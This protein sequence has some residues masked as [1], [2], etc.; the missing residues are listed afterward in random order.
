MNPRHLPLNYLY[1]GGALFFLLFLTAG[2]VFTKENLG[3]SQFFFFLYALGQIL[4][5]ISLFAF[6]ALGIR[7]YL[8]KIPLALFIGSTFAILI[9][10]LFDFMMDRVLDLSFWEAL[11]IFVL[12]ES[13]DNF[14]Y[15]LD[16][17]GVSLWMWGF[18]FLTLFSLPFLGIFL[19]RITELL[20]QKK[21]LFLR[22]THFFQ[23]FVCI[24][25]ALLLWDFSASKA[26]H[27]DAYTAFIKSLPWKF[28][29]FPPENVL[30]TLP[31]PMK[32]LPPET[33]VAA[34]DTPQKKPNIYLFVIESLRD[35]CITEEV[36]PNLH[37]FKQQFHHFDTALSNGNGTHISWFSI[38]HS[39]FPYYWSQAQK[40]YT[41]G[42]PALQLFK[43]WGY[44]LRLY[45]SAQL[46]YY[47][48]EQL[49]F[50]KDLQL[51]ESRQ[52]FHHSAPLSAADSDAQAL[53]KLQQDLANDPSLQEGQL[54]IIFWD[55]THFD[56][57]WPK[58]WT[59]KFKPFAGELAYFQ[60]FHSQNGIEKMKNRYKNSIHYLDHLFGQFFR[61]LPN[62]EE[63]I[64][65]VTG[66]HGEE[67]FDHGHLFHNSHLTH[68][69]IHVPLYFKFG[70]QKRPLA[71]RQV[72]SQMDIF[73]SLIDFVGDTTLPQL[74]GNSLFKAPKWPYVLTARFNA[75]LTPYE[76]SL[77]NGKHKVIAQFLNRPDIFASKQLQ[78]LSLRTTDDQ[79]LPSQKTPLPSEFVHAF[80]HLL[81]TE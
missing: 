50:G 22:H 56:Y 2:S 77:H 28:T 49:L 51:L 10:H 20:A 70:D 61:E 81:Q 72:V 18:F 52:T 40:T 36:A 59:P 78:I 5:E 12:H 13:L 35:D 71:P 3:G 74:E 63:S 66:D 47:G 15:L 9:T 76:F 58:Q 38:F 31:H 60:T 64:V 54:F 17:S 25:C 41:Q 43:E 53:T 37:E 14:M 24:P 6:L 75:G 39:Q 57:S 46:N 16:A 69:Q 34:L 33:A 68:E 32:S 27:P 44:K 7:K 21:P 11:K 1:F 29:F 79:S 4:L 55:S 65:I 73:P 23:L 30:F 45:S 62:R 19:Y 80:S 67:F 8:G 48:M 42:S 26:I